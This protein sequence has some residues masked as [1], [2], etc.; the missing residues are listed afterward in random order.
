MTGVKFE[1]SQQQQQQNVWWYR[2]VSN[3]SSSSSSNLNFCNLSPVM[4]R[5]RV[6]RSISIIISNIRFKVHIPE[7]FESLQT[8][9]FLTG[10]WTRCYFVRGYG[11]DP[12]HSGG[13]RLSSRKSFL[14]RRSN[15]IKFVSSKVMPPFTSWPFVSKRKYQPCYSDGIIV[16]QTTW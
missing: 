6:V 1:I 5:K 14:C 12:R 4:H 8:S 16:I 13:H 9:V 11:W 3:C 10:R 15:N 2:N 7:R